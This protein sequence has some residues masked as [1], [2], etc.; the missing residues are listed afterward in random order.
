MSGMQIKP[1]TRQ[2][3][4]PLVGL[5]SESGCGKTYSALLLARGMAGPNGSIVMVDTESGRGSLYADVIQ[6]GYQT[7][8]MGQPFSPE[9]YIEAIDLVES[10]GAKIGII[11]SASHEWEGIGGILDMASQNE[12]QSKRA[13]L[14]NWNK[15][16]MAHA[17][18]MLRMLQSSIPWIV[19]LRAKYKTR[20][21]K[22]EKGKTVIVKDDVTSPIQAEDFIFEMTAHAEILHNHHIRLTKCSHPLLRDC[23]PANGMIE[24]EHGR[25]LAE[26]C[27]SG[28]RPAQPGVSDA[29]ANLWKACAPI[30]GTAKTWD[31]AEAWMRSRRILTADQ[32][33]SEMTDDQ[34]VE[35]MEKVT[36]ELTGE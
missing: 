19:C 18:F 9:R 28:G 21:G 23:F 30:R 25:R 24:M 29:K 3:I 15:P 27:N 12:E 11:D 34:M 8:E 4:K 10:K 36:I 14:H 5:Y 31:A 6:G 7:I 26:W 22:D 20:Q 16:K 1:A 13:G 2:G 32:K 35:A 33:V 17:K